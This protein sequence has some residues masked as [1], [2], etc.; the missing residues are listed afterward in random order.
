LS[1]PT[2]GRR[3]RFAPWA[4]LALAL[5]G[6]DQGLQYGALADGRFGGRRVA[7]YD[8]P[9]F[10]WPQ[11]EELERARGL[12]DGTL[13]DDRPLGFDAELGWAPRPGR[14]QGDYGYDWCGAR[15]DGAATLAVRDPS[16]RRIALYGC[17]FTHGDGVAG[18]QTWAA[19]LE[20]LRPDLELLNFGVGAYGL[21]Q[22]LLRQRGHA[23]QVE[24]QEVWLGLLPA[25]CLRVTTHFRPIVR[26]WSTALAFKPR[27]VLGAAGEL[28]LRPNPAQSLADVVALCSDQRLFLERVAPGDRWIGRARAA[29]APRG[30]H[31]L[32]F[33]GLARLALTAHENLGRAHDAHLGVASAEAHRLLRAIVLASRDAAQA[34]GAGFRFLVLPGPTD[35][36]ELERDSPR[37][38]Q[39]LVDELRAAGVECFDATEAL[40]DLR[41][42]GSEL[43]LA[44]GHYTPAGNGAVGEAL[45]A[46][47]R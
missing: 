25:A 18:D 26:H 40:L 37:Y 30:T 24:P 44:D 17:S 38:W 31:P 14:A 10:H 22:A 41:R 27:F 3:R 47:S 7:P 11:Y 16:R 32:H 19:Q 5:L 13:P 34:R 36:A 12:L 8:P 45:A 4:L 42:S 6:L 1:A 46:L 33:S 21:D 35:L 9:L 2:A 29:Y 43:F 23:Q 28:V 39:L 20:A 15:D